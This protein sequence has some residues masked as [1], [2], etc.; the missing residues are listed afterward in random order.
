MAGCW[1]VGL[2]R[3]RERGCRSSQRGMKGRS[4]RTSHLYNCQ[5]SSSLIGKE[6][7]LPVPRPSITR[8]LP[9]P[10]AR[11]P[12]AV[13]IFVIISCAGL[14]RTLSVDSQRLAMSAQSRTVISSWDASKSIDPVESV[15]LCEPEDPPEPRDLCDRRRD[16]VDGRLRFGGGDDSK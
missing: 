8:T 11:G 12:T 9:P 15:D 1:C 7:E 3:G 4:R 6:E 14:T 16:E 2:R 5:H 13:V 10:L